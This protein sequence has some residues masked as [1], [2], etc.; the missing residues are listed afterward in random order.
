MALRFQCRSFRDSAPGFTLVELLVVIAI[1]GILVSLLL[2]AVQ[3]ARESARRMQCSNHLKQTGL[4]THNYYATFQAFPPGQFNYL[5]SYEPAASLSGFDWERR[6]WFQ[7]LLPYIEEGQLHAL[8]N[9]E[10]S[11]TE[12]RTNDGS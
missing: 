3:S 7:A 5:G 4:A 10:H 12:R 8:N 9:Q 2:P 11:A 1:I 6:C